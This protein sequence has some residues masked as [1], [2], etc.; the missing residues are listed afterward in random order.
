MFDPM[1][2]L[3]WFESWGVG[4]S[5][6]VALA[7]T[8]TVGYVFGRRMGRQSRPPRPV[9]AHWELQRASSIARNLESIVAETRED[10]SSHYISISQFK[11]KVDRL[12]NCESDASSKLIYEEAEKILAP[13]LKMAA[14]LSNA[15]DRIRQQSAQLLT[16][17]EGRT[18]PLTGA[19][20]QRAL[21]DQLGLRFE[22]FR[23][24]G[25]PFSLIIFDIDH[26]QEI[27]DERG[28][29]FGDQVLQ[30]VA[31]IFE[32]AVRDTDFVAR[33]GG[34]EFVVVM[35]QTRLAGARVFAERLRGLVEQ[36][37]LVT[38]SGGIAEALPEDTSQSVLSRADSALYSAKAAGRNA[39]FQHCGKT[40]SRVEIKDLTSDA[41]NGEEPRTPDD[42]AGLA[43]E[44]SQTE[45]L[46]DFSELAGSTSF[47]G[48]ARTV[49]TVS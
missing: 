10:L 43:V 19:G 38:V 15:Y 35:P 41:P 13:T 1:T 36:K 23:R 39:V 33:Y 44:S 32:Q 46:L 45:D 28:H 42:V 7:A 2:T 4:I 6:S 3:A 29:A 37:L 25:R 47:V 49:Q 31:R 11:S 22:M 16:F 26:F 18:D 27:N 21:D 12:S 34:E 20:N 17:A 48:A 24:N 30:G 9:H 40:I 5:E 14:L 8:A